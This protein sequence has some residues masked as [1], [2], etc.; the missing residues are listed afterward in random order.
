MNNLIDILKGCL[1]SNTVQQAES[2]L[3]QYAQK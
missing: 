3:A 2:L 1:F